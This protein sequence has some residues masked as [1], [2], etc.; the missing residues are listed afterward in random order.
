M[1][2]HEER[3]ALPGG[4]SDLRIGGRVE[5]RVGG[6]ASGGGE[7][8]RLRHREPGRIEAEIARG[9]EHLDGACSIRLDGHPHH[10]GLGGRRGAH[11]DDRRTHRVQVLHHRVRDIEVCHSLGPRIPGGKA[12]GTALAVDEHHPT[13]VEEREARLPEHP[14]GEADVLADVDHRLDATGGCPPVDAPEAG[15]V[16][17][18][19]ERAVG[20]PRGL[21]DRLP[22]VSARHHRA[23][24]A[25]VDHETDGIP[26]HVRVIPLEPAERTAVGA[27]AR[28]GHEVG[29]VRDHLGG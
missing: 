21:A 26:R 19:P 18:E 12:V 22:T 16:A 24:A 13:V 5:Q 8:D 11:V 3:R 10:V 4:G 29:T 14:L 9:H 25:L 1:N 17:A 20:G 7:L 2:H 23:L 6:S 27:P 15:A 28:I